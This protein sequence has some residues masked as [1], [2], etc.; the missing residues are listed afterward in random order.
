MSIF[1]SNIQKPGTAG[2]L[3]NVPNVLVVVF[4]QIKVLTINVYLILTTKR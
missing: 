1:E 3:G 4:E 2:L